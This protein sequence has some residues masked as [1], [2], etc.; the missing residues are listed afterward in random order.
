MF[1]LNSSESSR[2]SSRHQRASF[3]LNDFHLK[4]PSGVLLSEAM[5]YLI[6]PINSLRWEKENIECCVKSAPG[7]SREANPSISEFCGRCRVAGSLVALG[8]CRKSSPGF[9]TVDEEGPSY[10]R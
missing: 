2:S 3:S 4:Q 7:T 10:L 9:L 6:I 8:L 5:N 1:L